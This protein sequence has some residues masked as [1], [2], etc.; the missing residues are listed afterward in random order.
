MLASL[1]ESYFRLGP[2]LPV[3]VPLDCAEKISELVEYANEVDI[4]A[5]AHL[6]RNNF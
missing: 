1:H 5:A 6:L 3:P 2:V 4:A